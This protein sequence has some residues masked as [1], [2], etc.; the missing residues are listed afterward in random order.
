MSRKVPTGPHKTTRASRLRAT[1]PLSRLL[2]ERAPALPGRA[3]VLALALAGGA[4]AD[5]Y[6]EAYRLRERHEILPL[7]ELLQRAG[8]PP[9]ARILEIETEL[10]HGRRVYEIELLD[11]DGRIRELTIDARSGTVLSDEED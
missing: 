3:A 1:T 9:R 8:L 6:E 7:D 4:T 11:G 10:E 5:D 2:V